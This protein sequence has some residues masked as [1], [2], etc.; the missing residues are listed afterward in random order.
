M[1]QFCTIS[2][3]FSLRLLQMCFLPKKNT[4][5]FILESS[6]SVS[7]LFQ[8]HSVDNASLGESNLE[9]GREKQRNPTSISSNS[10]SLGMEGIF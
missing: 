6:L 2:L 10:G 5:D 3:S 8:D 1:I 7:H 9:N 4:K